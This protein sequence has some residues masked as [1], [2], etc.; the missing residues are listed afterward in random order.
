MKRILKNLLLFGMATAVCV[1]CSKESEV[2]KQED[3]KNN[4]E[5][6]E[7]VRESMGNES[8]EERDNN[9]EQNGVNS[10]TSKKQFDDEY[11]NVNIVDGAIKVAFSVSSQRKVYFSQGN[12]Q[13]QA[14]TNTWRFAEHQWDYVGSQIPEPNI[15]GGYVGKVGGTVEGSDNVNRSSTYDGWIDLFGWGTSGWESGAEVYQPYSVCHNGNKYYPGGSY[16]NELIGRYANAD[17]GVYNAISNGGNQPG[18]WRTL[19]SSEWY[20]VL[21]NR[22]DASAKKGLACI[23]GING[24]ILLPDNWVLPSGVSFKAGGGNSYYEY[25]KINNYSLSDWNKMETN[26]AVFLP[27]AG[28]FLST[29]SITYTS[30]FAV[31][32]ASH[33]GCY[34]ASSCGDRNCA[35]YL[36]CNGKDCGKISA[37]DRGDGHSI[38]L[39]QDIIE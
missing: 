18:T 38:R 39:V 29:F 11:V 1:A 8:N 28:H 37:I 15:G 3:Q 16:K 32:G 23:N 4:Q 25:A 26:G 9:Q 19:T 30:D 17:W 31:F 5:Q 2:S 12:L 20:Y 10:D 27:A 21:F 34:W 7:Q 24:L 14:S 33:Y 35:E 22:S 13:Y 6:S 36:E